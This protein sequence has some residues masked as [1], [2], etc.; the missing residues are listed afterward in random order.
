MESVRGVFGERSEESLEGL[1]GALRREPRGAKE[2]SEEHSEERSDESLKE[3]WRSTQSEESF[4][5]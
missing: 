1:G 4:L 3:C 2:C 5:G